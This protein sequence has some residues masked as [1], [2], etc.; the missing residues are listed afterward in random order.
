MTFLLQMIVIL[1]LSYV[2][3]KFIKSQRNLK[4]CL[5][6]KVV[7][8][9]GASSGIGEALAHSFYVAGCRLILTARRKD[10]LERVRKDLLEIHST[11][12][13]HPPVVI[14]MDLT[15]IKS[16]KE[17]AE[18]ALNIHGQIDIVVN[19]GGIV[20]YGEVVNTK[21]EDVM[22]VMMT[23]YF[24]TVELTKAF[25][26]SMIK[27]KKGRIVC[28]SSVNGKIATPYAAPYAASKFALQAFCDSLRA[29]V[30]DDNLKVT[31]ISPGY[32]ATPILRNGI[33]STG[34]LPEKRDP[35]I[36]DGI[37][38][39]DLANGVL[40][41]VLDDKKDVIISQLYVEAAY[42]LSFL[43]PSLFHWIMTIRAR[44]GQDKP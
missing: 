2:A 32:V 39:D 14:T 9:T 6:N 8:I 40:R 43:C 16:L 31:I 22:K 1:V 37:R 41:A 35:D 42:W 38:P 24:G 18:Q 28:I 26:P 7:L 44:T 30:Y 23:N 10:E 11:K 27:K 15:D 17:K 33:T 5:P 3:Y 25:L 34:K 36:S 4:N 12:V 21:H 13:T 29:E 19:N 20:Y